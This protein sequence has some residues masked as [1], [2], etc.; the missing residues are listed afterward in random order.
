[1][2]ILTVVRRWGKEVGEGGWF[3]MILQLCINC[4]GYSVLSGV[5]NLSR[6]VNVK[7]NC[8]MPLRHRGLIEIQLYSFFNFG[9]GSQRHTQL[10]YPLERTPITIV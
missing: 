10:F 3:K 2:G 7:K 9:V 5:V 8:N 6:V 1:L 4:I